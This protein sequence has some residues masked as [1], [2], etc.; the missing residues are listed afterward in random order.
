MP[1]KP[2]L[3]MELNKKTGNITTWY[4]GEKL[5]GI[6]DAFDV[7]KNPHHAKRYMAEYRKLSKFA[8]SNVGYM[9]GYY[10]SKTMRELQERFGVKHP[11]FGGAV[12]TAKE[13]FEVGIGVGKKRRKNAARQASQ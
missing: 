11:I 1:R 3:K 13:A 10:D 8:D 4:M 9:T 6:T 7:I 12:P 2:I 5:E